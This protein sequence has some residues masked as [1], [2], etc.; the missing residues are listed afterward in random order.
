[1][2]FLTWELLSLNEPFR[3]LS[4]SK[5]VSFNLL[6]ETFTIPAL[7]P[8]VN[9]NRMFS[10][11]N[12]RYVLSRS[13]VSDSLRHRLQP[14]RLLSMEFSR[15]EYWSGL[16]FPPP[17]DFP[18]PEI[19][20]L[21]PVSP[22]LAGRLF[23]TAPPALPPANNLLIIRKTKPA[24]SYCAA[25]EWILLVSSLQKT[26]E[27]DFLGVQLFTSLSSLSDEWPLEWKDKSQ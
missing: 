20:P 14:S 15:Q 27:D 19:E 9:N 8:I 22:A 21:S 18:D 2:Q 5:K 16:P 24:F 6:K 10:R 12:E 13:V 25:P 1:M 7:S 4:D 26:K 17:G 23:T 11:F 3:Q